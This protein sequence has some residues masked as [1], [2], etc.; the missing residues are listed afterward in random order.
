MSSAENVLAHA[1]IASTAALVRY[2]KTA[3]ADSSPSAIDVAA[4]AW[5]APAS[6]LFVPDKGLLLADWLVSALT[7]RAQ[8]AAASKAKG[9]GK[10]RKPI[11]EQEHDNDRLSHWDLLKRVLEA[12][13]QLASVLASRHAGALIRAA[14]AFA[15]RAQTLASAESFELAASMGLTLGALIDPTIC[16]GATTATAR[17]RMPTLGEAIA[18]L[19]FVAARLPASETEAE[20]G[21]SRVLQSMLASYLPAFAQAAPARREAGIE[22]ALGSF[23][24][25]AALSARAPPKQTGKRKRFSSAKL[26]STLA[27]QARSFIHETLLMPETL[28]VL[29]T[30]PDKT[31][32]LQR[33]VASA[34]SGTK[35]LALAPDLLTALTVRL[36]ALPI[37]LPKKED[38][39]RSTVLQFT[40]K[41]VSVVGSTD[42]QRSLLLAQ[43]ISA[44][45]HAGLYRPGSSLDGQGTS[46]TSLLSAV[47]EGPLARISLPESEGRAMDLQTVHTLWTV[48]S[49]PVS[50]RL[51]A[52][53]QALWLTTEAVCMAAAEQL[54]R[55]IFDTAR[56]ARGVPQLAV[57][58][59]DAAHKASAVVPDLLLT[60]AAPTTPRAIV[61]SA[62]ALQSLPA[63]LAAGLVQ[64]LAQRLRTRFAHAADKRTWAIEAF[65]AA[66]ILHTTT[67]APDAG[68]LHAWVAT[69]D[70]V[71]NFG[72]RVQDIK[73]IRQGEDVAVV[74]A[75]L[76]LWASADA[77]LS[78]ARSAM[79]PSDTAQEG[80][81][82]DMNR[83]AKV[84]QSIR[85]HLP[86]LHNI[87]KA[88]TD[89]ALRL[90]LVRLVRLRRPSP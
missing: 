13:P 36:R 12:E 7:P 79:P 38:I 74:R 80:Y 25:C 67:L 11:T 47:L 16:A 21:I 82:P 90:D 61:L 10:G 30:T 39:I 24:D 9:S 87:F 8:A 59:I 65:L 81:L 46:W 64:T 57:A 31:D 1:G 42:P 43:T 86:H 54:L 17:E 14:E 70:A 26:P 62:E 89:T 37:E 28:Q 48:D 5:S 4:A 53:L 60:N 55:V 75:A 85:P 3:S 88:A 34:A 32:G 72:A 69:Y 73:K 40:S 23:D 18:R 77:S 84:S 35:A 41:L 58:L 78:R 63:T 76:A 20:A 51:S 19:V 71:G 49:G 56:R 44:A 2:I 68:G 66:Q 45:S 83:L 50:V 27:D 6:L 15:S 29:L 33:V 22:A 52:I